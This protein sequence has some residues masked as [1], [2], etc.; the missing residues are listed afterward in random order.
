MQMDTD[1]SVCA[2]SG[3]RWAEIKW[4]QVRRQVKKLQARIVKATQGGKQG[5]VKALQWLLTHSFSGKA[6]S[7]KLVTENRKKNTHGV[8]K[9]IWNT[10]KAKTNA[11]SAQ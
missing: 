5:K 4:S 10:S 2:P 9:V 11:I 1:L 7:V 8:D 3:H 6:L